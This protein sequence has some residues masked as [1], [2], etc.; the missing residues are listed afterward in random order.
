MK[1]DF[2]DNKENDSERTNRNSNIKYPDLNT[3]PSKLI[4]FIIN[5]FYLILQNFSLKI[6]FLV[7]LIKFKSIHL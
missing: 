5:L 3:K 7:S 2:K 4:N 6:Q 1:F